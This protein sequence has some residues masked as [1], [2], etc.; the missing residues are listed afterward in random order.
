MHVALNLNLTLTLTVIL[1]R[2]FLLKKHDKQPD[3]VKG[4]IVVTPNDLISWLKKNEGLMS[5]YEGKKQLKLQLLE[6]KNG[7]YLSV[8]TYKKEGNE[9]LNRKGVDSLP[10]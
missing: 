8:D 10:F 1:Y 6:G 5:E 4:S 9:D 2:K 3:F 7:L